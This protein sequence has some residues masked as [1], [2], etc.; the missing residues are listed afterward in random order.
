MLRAF[1]CQAEDEFCA[2]LCVLEVSRVLVSETCAV[3]TDEIVLRLVRDR[4]EL[5]SIYIDSAFVAQHITGHKS[6]SVN[7]IL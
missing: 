7:D 5:N 2:G 4:T 1:P 3:G 6:V